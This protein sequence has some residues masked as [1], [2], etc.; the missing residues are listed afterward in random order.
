MSKRLIAFVGIFLL[1]IFIISINVVH[2][3]S[4]ISLDLINQER[5][6]RGLKKIEIDENLC[7]L[8]KM[9]AEDRELAYPE[10]IDDS[11][12]SNPKYKPFIKDYSSYIA[13]VLTINDVLVKAYKDEGVTIPLFTD[14]QIAKQSIK[15]G[16]AIV[17]EITHGCSAISSGKIGYK[18]YAYFIGGVKKEIVNSPT[19]ITVGNIIDV[20]LFT[21][22]KFFF[23]NFFS[24]FRL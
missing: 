14:E 24:K 10:K 9:L 6:N 22:I 23:I 4:N 16:E 20:S 17:P 7:T 5:T 11:P 13:T 18:S 2:A 12:F 19:P 3:S 1:L 8:A 21:K 15:N